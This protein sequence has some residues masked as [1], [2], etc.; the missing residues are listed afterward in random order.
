MAD[1]ISGVTTTSVYEGPP[2]TMGRD[3]SSMYM[4]RTLLRLNPYKS[5]TSILRY[6]QYVINRAGKRM[7]D[8]HRQRIKHAME[9]IK[10]L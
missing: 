8:D 7:S 3:K 5:K 2:G 9:L 4:A 6:M 10:R 1:W